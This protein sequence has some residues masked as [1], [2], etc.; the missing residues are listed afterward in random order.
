MYRT[1]LVAA[2]LLGGTLSFGDES[3]VSQ[4]LLV[5]V[6]DVCLKNFFKLVKDVGFNPYPREA[7]PIRADQIS[8]ERRVELIRLASEW[9]TSNG[10]L[11]CSF[12]MGACVLRDD[13]G[14]HG[15]YISPVRMD[16]LGFYPEAVVWF[17]LDSFEV[18][19]K[20]LFHSPC[21][22]VSLSPD[23]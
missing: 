20:V 3:D 15:V 7:T 9:A 1:I 10:Y 5:D 17:R 11:P 12:S 22:R 6:T 8:R 13:K 18:E 16:E 2:C 14:A 4:D 21:K 19:D 23:I